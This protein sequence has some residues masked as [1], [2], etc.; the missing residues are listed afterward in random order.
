MI[1]A[2]KKA[3]WA[4]SKMNFIHNKAG[5]RIKEKNFNQIASDI[6]TQ[7]DE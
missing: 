5:K 1:Q 3:K 7:M 4:S 6:S 2:P